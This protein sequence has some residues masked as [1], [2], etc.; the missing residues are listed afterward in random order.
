M[1]HVSRNLGEQLRAHGDDEYWLVI[2]L[3]SI[4]VCLAQDNDNSHKVEQAL[5]ENE[6]IQK[7]VNFFQNCPE[8]HFV[9]ILE[10][11]LKIITVIQEPTEITNWP[12]INGTCTLVISYKSR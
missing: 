10:P 12:I 7:L 5:L 4:F 8:R 3:D 6:A 9:H 1:A 2:A 11:F